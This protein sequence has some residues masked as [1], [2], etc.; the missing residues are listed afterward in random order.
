MLGKYLNRL[1]LAVLQLGIATRQINKV[2]LNAQT[3]ME[4]DEVWFF[5]FRNSILAIA[6]L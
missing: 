6:F 3:L 2:V 4:K 1:F 5:E